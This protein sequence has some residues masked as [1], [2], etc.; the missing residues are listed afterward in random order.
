MTRKVHI[1]EG[2]DA[3]GIY[4]YACGRRE[5]T[6]VIRTL[7]GRARLKEYGF[8]VTCAPCRRKYA[9]ELPGTDPEVKR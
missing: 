5:K 4:I 1:L 6:R 2:T 7:V 3:G 8:E 9:S